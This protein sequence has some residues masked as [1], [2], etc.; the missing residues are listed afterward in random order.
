MNTDPLNL[1][2]LPPLE[3]PSNLWSAIEEQT[4]KSHRARWRV[5]APA[6][7]AAMVLGVVLTVLMQAPQ[8]GPELGS[9]LGP[10]D[11]TGPASPIQAAMAASADLESELRA[12]EQGSVSGFALEHLLL[13]EAELA[14]VDLR[15]AER[16]Q[17]LGLWQQ[18]SELLAAMI[19]R[20]AEPVELA[21]WSTELL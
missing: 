15:L 13:L 21:L 16:P 11:S 9:E 14:W 18:R 19:L 8:P 4:R 1:R 17:D 7:A 2:R 5:W 6:V 10:V 12:R 20:Y 3:P